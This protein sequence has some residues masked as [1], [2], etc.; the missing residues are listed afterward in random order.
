[1]NLLNMLIISVLGSSAFAQM[2]NSQL[3][4]QC[5]GSAAVPFQEEFILTIEDTKYP[6]AGAS[7]LTRELEGLLQNSPLINVS[8]YT[9]G[10]DTTLVVFLGV[11]WS[12]VSL[13]PVNEQYRYTPRIVNELFVNQVDKAMQ[14]SSLKDKKYTLSC[15]MESGNADMLPRL[16]ST[17]K[18]MLD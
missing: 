3:I 8:H 12:E 9:P 6:A 1:M 7:D 13:L 10:G 11:K 16:F 17:D 14:A 2:N 4:E 15:R 18:T 5:F